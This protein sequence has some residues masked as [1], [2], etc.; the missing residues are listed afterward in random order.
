MTETWRDRSHDLIY[1]IQSWVDD[2]T[3]EEQL[4]VRE[5]IRHRNQQGIR[6]GESV[7]PEYEVVC[8]K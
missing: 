4:T 6:Q 7:M 2:R 5:T 3:K 8:L 1:G